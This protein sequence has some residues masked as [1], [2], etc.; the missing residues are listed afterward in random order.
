[1]AVRGRTA[2][3]PSR[4]DQTTDA[5]S[6]VD[7]EHKE[8]H[9][10]DAFYVTGSAEIDATQLISHRFTTP[11]TA[12]WMHFYFVVEAQGSVTVQIIEGI[13]NLIES[14]TGIYNRNRNYSDA[15]ATMTHEVYNNTAGT[16]GTVIWAW[17]S[18]GAIGATARSP[19]VTRQSGEIVLKQNTKY[20]VK[21]TS[22][23]NDNTITAYV[24]W[25]E[26][27]NVEN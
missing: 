22:N 16:G 9:T 4:I 26:H 27:T 21:I 3:F 14:S 23:V 17:T 24:T 11:N 12:E 1:M 25:Y 13:S 5:S 19:G 15:L 18:G 6:I 20:E 8:V 7:Y 10:G 2:I